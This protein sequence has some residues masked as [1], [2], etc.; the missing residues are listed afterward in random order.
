MWNAVAGDGYSGYVALR[1]MLIPV[2]SHFDATDPLQRREL[3]VF[4][5]TLLTQLPGDIPEAACRLNAAICHLDSASLLP[6]SAWC[7]M[8]LLVTHFTTQAHLPFW[9]PGR[10]PLHSRRW[11]GQRSVL[12]GFPD[13]QSFS[14]AYNGIEHFLVF[15]PNV[16]DQD[17]REA[18]RVL[19]LAL[20]GDPLPDHWISITGTSLQADPTAAPCT[21]Y[22]SRP[23]SPMPHD[24]QTTSDGPPSPTQLN[25]SSLLHAQAPRSYRA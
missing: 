4:L 20:K 14:V 7:H 5:S 16:T 21:C 12:T 2:S 18:R 23:A 19:E 6:R 15:Q 1:R 22:S 9:T 13:L 8:D 11:M 24:A 25:P 17:Q 3:Q 10:T